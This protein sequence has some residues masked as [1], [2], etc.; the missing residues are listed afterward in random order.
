MTDTAHNAAHLGWLLDNLV[1]QIPEVRYA[2][3]TSS[4]GL[5][6]AKSQDLPTNDAEH[7]SAVV[8]GMSSL[9]RGFSGRFRYGPVAHSVIH[10]AEAVLFIT[11]AGSGA[12]LAALASKDVDLS[13]LAFE[14]VT[15][16]NQVGHQHLTA[17]PRAQISSGGLVQ[18]A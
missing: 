12:R 10:M 7:T 5:L 6:I 16:V 2:I 15:L 4:D 8:S 18:D 3:V 1:T 13:I 11:D 14:A 9:A 17:A